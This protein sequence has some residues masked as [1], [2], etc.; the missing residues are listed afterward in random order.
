MT[1]D[2]AELAVWVRAWAMSRHRPPPAPAFG[3]WF[4]HVGQPDQESRYVFPALDAVRLRRLGA[5]IREPHVLLKLPV[6]PD[7]V[8]AVLGRD[9]V[10]VRTGWFMRIE[11]PTGSAEDPEGYRVE[12]EEGA[13]SQYR[14][15]AVDGTEA[16]RARLTVLGVHASVDSVD[17]E[18]AFRR[19]GLASALMRRMSADARRK[20]ASIGLLTSTDAGRTVYE[21]LG[22]TLL[23]PWTTAQLRIKP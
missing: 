7:A 17:T 6:E 3:G 4:V 10:S 22:W 11:L 23:A 14:V 2:P 21:R 12:V 18:P 1:V 15:L 16:A 5:A 19:T 13:T 8:Q 9:W 20:G